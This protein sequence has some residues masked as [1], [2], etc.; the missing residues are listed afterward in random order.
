MWWWCLCERTEVTNISTASTVLFYRSFLWH[1][2]A[3]PVLNTLNCSLF[4]YGHHLYWWMFF[5]KDALNCLNLVQLLV[6]VIQSST[7]LLKLKVAKWKNYWWLAPYFFFPGCT[8]Y[9]KL[10]HPQQSK[11]FQHPCLSK[12][13]PNIQ[14]NYFVTRWL[15]FNRSCWWAVPLTPIN[16]PFTWL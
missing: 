11:C 4:S 6:E 9:W 5:G 2:Y 14:A 1:S 7:H 13:I 10:V 15:C 3:G 8:Q 16:K 12:P